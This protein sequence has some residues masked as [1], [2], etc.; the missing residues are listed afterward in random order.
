MFLAAGTVLARFGHD[1]IGEL[2]GLA[3]RA[4]VTVMTFALAGVTMM[5]LPPSA[6]FIVKWEIITASIES[7]QWWWTI[8]V[9]AG[10]LLAAAYVFR[11]VGPFLGQPTEQ[12]DF[13]NDSGRSPWTM[14]GSALALAL[15]ALV[16]GVVG[17]PLVDLIMTGAPALIAGVTS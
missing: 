8:V 17:Q 6:G 4:P 2:G 3:R 9:V 14:E 12:S 16:L 5:G 7:G 15:A 13:H 10:G 1:R 11:V